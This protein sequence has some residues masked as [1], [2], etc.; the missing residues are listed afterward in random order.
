MC[1]VI[2]SNSRRLIENGLHSNDVVIIAEYF[3]GNWVEYYITIDLNPFVVPF[4][5]YIS[6]KLNQTHK[7][8]QQLMNF[9]RDA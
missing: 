7:E 1:F 4:V 3:I 8:L 9:D 6:K 5:E 2:I